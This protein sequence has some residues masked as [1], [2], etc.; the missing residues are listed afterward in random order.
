MRHPNTRA[1][2]FV[3]SMSRR[4]FLRVGGSALAGAALLGVA[5]CSGTGGQSSS[6]ATE[7]TFSFGPDNSGSLEEIVRRFN[8]RF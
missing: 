7:F 2:A 6:G 1:R 8:E 4:G 5:G 3:R